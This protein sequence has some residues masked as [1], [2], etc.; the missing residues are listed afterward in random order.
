M[1]F[2]SSAGSRYNLG[3]QVFSGGLETMQL[4]AH[5]CLG[6]P[7]SCMLVSVDL[8][9]CTCSTDPENIGTNLGMPA[10]ET[11]LGIGK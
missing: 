1:S 9:Q 5:T 2:S 4:F 3:K 8:G 10:A 7:L 6:A 11:T